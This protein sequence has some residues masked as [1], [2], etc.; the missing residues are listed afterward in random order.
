[1]KRRGNVLS[2]IDSINTVVEM[3]IQTDSSVEDGEIVWVRSTQCLW[4]YRVNS[5]YVPDGVNIVSSLYGNGVWVRTSLT[6]GGNSLPQTAWFIDPTLGNDANNG[7]TAVTAL[8]TDAERQRRWGAL[9]V[10]GATTTVTYLGSPPTTD[11]VNYNAQ[12]KDGA[13]LIV[14]GQRTTTKS[15]ALTAVTVLNRGTQTPWSVTQQLL[16]V[17]DI[18]S[19]IRIT[20]GARA[21]AYA[22]IMKS[23]GGGAVRTTPF[24]TFALSP[25]PLTVVTPQIGDPYEVVTLPTL[26]IGSA[27]FTQLSNNFQVASPPANLVQFDSLL[28]DGNFTLGVFSSLGIEVYFSQCLMQNLTFTGC[29]NT[30]F[31]HAGGGI[32]GC[33]WKACS[34]ALALACGAL[35]NSCAAFS[36]GHLAL[37]FDCLFQNSELFVEAD[38]DVDGGFVSFFDSASAD[39]ALFVDSQG[40]Y[41][42]TTLASSGDLLWGTGNAGHGAVVKSTGRIVYST[43]PTINGGLGA[44]RESLVGGTDKQW[45]AIPF[46]DSGAAASQAAIVVFA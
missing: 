17:G 4:I 30:A 21:G 34:Q 28:L 36:G 5:G 33:V 10:I 39:T 14:K 26:E 42:S 37:D 13:A 8:K 3:L 41:R 31:R 24:A 1:M 23:L 29:P 16:G 25:I 6:L 35:N 38:T 12:V 20:G 40:L 46:A 15:G 45:G 22:R 43:K 7:L 19:I 44:G 32:D 18:G 27:N 2:P 11:Q 9:A